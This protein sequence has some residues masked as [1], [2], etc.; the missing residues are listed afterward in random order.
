M[1]QLPFETSQNIHIDQVT[2]T[3]LKI[4]YHNT[5]LNAIQQKV[6]ECFVIDKLFSQVEQYYH[7]PTHVHMNRQICD[8]RPYS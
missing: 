1:A 2:R 6:Q 3:L 5:V 8:N 7:T 4:K